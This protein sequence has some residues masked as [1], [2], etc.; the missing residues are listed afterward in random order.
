MTSKAKYAQR[1]R[2][3]YRERQREART[4]LN[5]CT[6]KNTVKQVQQNTK[7][8]GFFSKLFRRRTENNE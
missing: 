6:Y 7:K 8:Q 1:S 2:K 3:T 5:Q 4:F